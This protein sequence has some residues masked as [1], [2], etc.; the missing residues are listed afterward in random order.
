MTFRVLEYAFEK[1]FPL[2][3]E[4]RVCRGILKAVTH[5]H[6]V[7]QF[8]YLRTC[9]YINVGYSST[10]NLLNPQIFPSEMSDENSLRIFSRESYQHFPELGSLYAQKGF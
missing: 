5:F 8:L 1:I 3:V 2:N 10:H 6:L 4:G 9:F 7:S